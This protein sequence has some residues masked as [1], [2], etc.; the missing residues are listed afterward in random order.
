MT[1][2]L[3]TIFDTNCALNVTKQLSW[4]AYT[5]SSMRNSTILSEDIQIELECQDVDNMAN[6]TTLLETF[7]SMTLQLESTYL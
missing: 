7:R 5:R 3:I 4:D 2:H 6:E 1:L